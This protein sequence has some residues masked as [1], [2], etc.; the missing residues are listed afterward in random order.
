MPT[1]TLTSENLERSGVCKPCLRF[2]HN[3]LGKKKEPTHARE[4][5]TERAWIVQVEKD[6]LAAQGAEA[7]P[8]R[9]PLP[10]EQ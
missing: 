1:I 8:Q 6:C 7:K 4:C 9:V 3:S 2:T 5:F 10:Q